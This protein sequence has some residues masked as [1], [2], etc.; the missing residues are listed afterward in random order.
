MTGQLVAGQLVAEPQRASRRRQRGFTLIE[1]LVV[2]T[3]I[4]IVV[5]L[6]PMAFTRILPG[7]QVKTAARDV[8]AT[9]REARGLAIRDNL[10]VAVVVDTATGRYG[11]A[12]RK[13]ET[14]IGEGIAVTLHTAVSERI[15]DARGRIRFYPDGTATGGGVT[16]QRGTQSY[17]VLVDW[18][19]GRVQVVE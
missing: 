3:I 11:V 6:A 7:L 18:L 10:E 1:L 12:G 15:D 13:A 19:T 16:L 8:A 17:D 2:L 5:A 4:G 14:P 9:F